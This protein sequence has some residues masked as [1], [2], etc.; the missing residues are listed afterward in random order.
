[1]IWNA[2]EFAASELPPFAS[3]GQKFMRAVVALQAHSLRATLRCQIEGASFLK[4]RFEDDLKLLE[5]LTGGDEFVDAF[6]V[7]AN[8]VQNATSDYA[9]E[10]GKFASIGAKLASEAAGRVRK[11]A[12]TTIDDM[13]AATL[14]T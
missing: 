8:F 1:M 11:E 10:V 14:A 3:A 4:R 5:K 2:D 6:D 9:G 12:E 13:A 7:F